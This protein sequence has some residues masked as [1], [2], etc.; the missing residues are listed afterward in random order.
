M[1]DRL[2]WGDRAVAI[3]LDR[4]IWIMSPRGERTR[5]HYGSLDVEDLGS[6]YEG[7][8]EQEP[9]IAAGPLIRLRRGKT[10]AVVASDGQASRHRRPDSSSCDRE[11]AAKPRDRS[12]R[13]TNLFVSWCARR[14][15]PKIAALSPPDD[16]HPAKLLT[17]KIVD[18]ATGSGH[19]LV[20]ACRYLGEALLTRLPAVR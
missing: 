18:P 8:L 19:F 5:V 17:L 13:R 3:L 16:P 11:Q 20:E 4:L 12:T 15:D 9:G 10:E 6:I 2:D 1:L 14:L 7:L